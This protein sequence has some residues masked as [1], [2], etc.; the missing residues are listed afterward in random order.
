LAWRT[1]HWFATQPN[2]EMD[3]FVGKAESWL[4]LWKQIIRC[5]LTLRSS[6]W[7]AT[8]LLPIAAIM[9][10]QFEYR[11]ERSLIHNMQALNVSFTK[12]PLSIVI[13]RASA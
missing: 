13:G 11:V 1:N 2:N 6:P 4:P 12:L 5:L 3:A 8:C 10:S 9:S 7:G